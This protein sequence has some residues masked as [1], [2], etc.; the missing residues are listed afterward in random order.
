MR[1]AYTE[2][3]RSLSTDAKIEFIQYDYESVVSI[4]HFGSF[5]DVSQ[6]TV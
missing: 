4:N 3:C 2:R 5:L 1:Y 6:E